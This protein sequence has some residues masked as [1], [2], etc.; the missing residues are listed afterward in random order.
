[1]VSVANSP[2]KMRENS[3]MPYNILS[4]CKDLCGLLILHQISSLTASIFKEIQLAL[5]RSFRTSSCHIREAFVITAI[6]IPSGLSNSIS[7]PKLT[8][9]VGSPPG[10][11]V[12]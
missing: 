2:P 12:R 11:K 9:K 5:H 6:L 4:S 8:S 1:M 10:T 7:F 3:I